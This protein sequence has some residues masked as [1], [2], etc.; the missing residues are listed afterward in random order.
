MSIGHKGMLY[1]AKALSMTMVDLFTDKALLD[2]VKQEFKERKGSY[3]YEGLLP[4]GP[5]PVGQE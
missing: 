2:L 1:A 3:Q 5:P 4:P